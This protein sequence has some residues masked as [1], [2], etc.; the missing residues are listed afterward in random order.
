M[1]SGHNAYT[2][3]PPDADTGFSARLVASPRAPRH[4]GAMRSILY[5]ASHRFRDASIEDGRYDVFRGEII[6]GN[7][8]RDRVGRRELHFLVDAR[9]TARKRAAEDAGK[10]EHVVDLI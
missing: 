6:I 4:S 2:G 1:R 8:R 9:G 7:R 10:A 3:P 5:I